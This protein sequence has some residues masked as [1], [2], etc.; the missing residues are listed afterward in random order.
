[1]TDKETGK[2][3]FF[4]HHAEE[5]D[6]TTYSLEQRSRL[7]VL[8]GS[9]S[10]KRGWRIL[11]VG[12]GT[13]ILVPFLLRSVGRK[14]AIVGLDISRVMLGKAKE[15]GFPANVR[16]VEARAE[17]IP[18]RERAFDAAV[19]FSVFPHFE[20]HPQA[21]REIA[22]VLKPGGALYILHLEGSERLNAFHREYGGAVKHDRLPNAE[23]M[24][25]LL[26]A[27]GFEGISV[28]DRTDLYL[29]K[30]RRAIA[31]EE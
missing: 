10:L 2:R 30:A 20:R 7:G 27:C 29:A 22:R 3:S 24:G 11:D 8:V 14:G 17:Q 25:Q 26:R 28:E 6:E 12:C 31:R 21:L 18:L 1:M 13:G 5:W 19:C 15:K 9:F 16:F 4:D 23:G